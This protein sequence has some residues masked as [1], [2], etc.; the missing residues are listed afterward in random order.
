MSKII[1]FSQKKTQLQ[2]NGKRSSEES[3]FSPLTYKILGFEEQNSDSYIRQLRSE[4]LAIPNDKPQGEIFIVWEEI[5]DEA[6][7]GES[8]LLGVFGTKAEAIDML[9]TVQKTHDDDF[10]ALLLITLE[11]VELSQSQV[12]FVTK[13]IDSLNEQEIARVI[14]GDGLPNGYGCYME[15]SIDEGYSRWVQKMEAM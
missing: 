7:E 5:D 8:T 2:V 12:H 9:R 10:A 13:L 4:F 14:R 6:Y 3:I 15:T 1:P 11:A